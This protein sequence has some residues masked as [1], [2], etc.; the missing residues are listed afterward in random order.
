[1]RFELV[2][3]DWDGTLMDSE[4]RIVDC[5]QSAFGELGLGVPSAEAARDIIG[6]GL[7]EA[8]AEL[9]PEA[10]VSTRAD[11]VLGYRRQFLLTNETPSVLF[12][13]AREVLDWL[14]GSGYRLAVA[15]GKSRRGLDKSLAETGLGGVFHATRCAD[16]TFSKPHPQMLFELM[17]ELGAAASQTL[18]IG[19]TEY[20]MQMAA[21]AGVA[22]LAVCYGVHAADRL[23]SHQ[24]LAC[25]ESLH[26]L[27]GWL[28][29]YGTAVDLT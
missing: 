7:E 1:M 6:L 8:I 9:A 3:F 2:V 13:G 18:M 4:A 20:D 5:I 12:P 28:K 17:D 15:T 22:A 27:P 25:L 21:N 10:S 23:L 24:P 19:D 26:G 14:Q 11:L 16:E 29:G